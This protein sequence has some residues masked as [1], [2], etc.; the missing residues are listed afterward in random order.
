MII[1]INLKRFYLPFSW[2]ELSFL[3]VTVPLLE[4]SLLFTTKFQGVSVTDLINLANMRGW[5]NLESLMGFE[6]EVV[7]E[8]EVLWKQ[9][10]NHLAIT[11]NHCFKT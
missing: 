9:R 11:L 6:L 2:M 10:P 7:E 5:V 8:L 3:K 4:D 1:P